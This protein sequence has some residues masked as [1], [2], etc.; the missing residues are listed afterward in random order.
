VV[1]KVVGSNPISHPFKKKGQ[2]VQADLFCAL[3]STAISGSTTKQEDLSDYAR[4]RVSNK[5]PYLK[6]DLTFAVI[7]GLTRNPLTH[8]YVLRDEPY[9]AETEYVVA[10]GRS[11]GFHVSLFQ[12]L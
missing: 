6:S 2:S 11:G 10:V 12:I 4:S 5:C 3:C 7:A 1:P 8:S 9:V